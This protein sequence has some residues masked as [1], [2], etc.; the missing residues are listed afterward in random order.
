[1]GL[2]ETMSGH[3]K[4]KGPELDAL[5]AIPSA[6]ITLEAGAGFVATG[7]GSV[8]YRGASGAAF[9]ETQ[10]DIVALL[11]D[12]PEAPDV[13]IVEDD[14]GFT[15]LTVHGD[16]TDTA[17]L[18]TDLHAVN[19]MLAEQGFDSGLLCTL[20]PFGDPDGRRFGLVYLYRSGTFYPFAPAGDHQR[21]NLLEFQVRDLLAGELPVEEDLTRWLAVWGAPGL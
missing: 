7:V 3:R 12:D 16:P 15:W 4:I 11:N 2:W 9:H 1:M 19:T 10:S 21:D 14:F 13:E 6:A 17:G 8:C 18:C 20:V 5:F